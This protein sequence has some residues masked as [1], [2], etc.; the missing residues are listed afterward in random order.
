MS[1]NVLTQEP[2]K[3][4]SLGLVALIGVSGSGKST[5]ARQ[6]F[7]PT[8]VLSSDTCRGWVADDEADQTATDD[9]F[10]VLYAVAERRLRR[11]KL[12]VVDATS[13]Q[14]FAR[15][16]IVELARTQHVFASA[17]VLDVPLD[18][19]LAR[20]AA[21]GDRQV[22]E[23]AIRRQYKELRRSLDH[24]KK[25]G[26]RNV[27]VLT[28]EQ[29]VA[30]A[31]F[32]RTRMW[33]DRTD[34]HGPFDII[35][36]VHGCIDELEA[37]LGQLGYQAADR[38]GQAVWA[39]PEGR[40]ALF[41]GDLCDR[42]PGTP[43]VYRLVMA[44]VRHKTGLCIP[45]NHEIKLLKWLQGRNVRMTHGLDR[46][47]QQL[48]AEP[49]AFR[50]EVAAF[51]DRLIS[52]FVLDDGKL[53]VAHAG[54]KEAMQG[55]SSGGV[56][57]FCLYGET[58]GET[59]EYGLPV[60]V[61][62]AEQYR[63]RALVVYGH[64]PVLSVQWRHNTVC[65][66]T[67]CV[68]GGALTALRYPE[69]ETVSVPARQV[70]FASP[71]PLQPKAPVVEA[72][73]DVADLLG[74][75]TIETRLGF[76]VSISERDAAGGLEVMARFAA[77][78]RWLVYL[79]PTMSPCETAP[80]GEPWLEHPTQALAYYRE[81]GV[82]QVVCEQKHMGSRAV[83]V[84]CKDGPAAQAA[85]SIDN[86]GHGVVLSRT[87][88]AF[89][90]DEA[91]QAAVLDRLRE[92]CTAA[93]LWQELG[94]GW[95]LFDC[96][97]LPWS[98]KARQLIRRQFA[99]TGAAGEAGLAAA[100]AALARKGPAASHLLDDYAAR[101]RAV[102][103]YRTAYRSYCRPVAG[104]DDLRLAPFHLLASAG[105]VHTDKDHLWHM[106]V[107]ER[108]AQAEPRL[109]VATQHR[110][111]QLDDDGSCS[112]A[113]AWWQQLVDAGGEGMVCKP[114]Q[115]LTPGK[116]GLVQPAV[117]CRGPE[118]LRI[119]Y[120]PEYLLPA[121]L[122]RLRARGLGGKRSL[123]MREFALGI[124]GLQ[125]FVAGESQRRVHEC[126]FGV[127]ALESEPGDPRL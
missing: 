85:F 12:T 66:D 25:E 118:Y 41:L 78:P 87:G 59:D 10:A 82:A 55:R 75:R 90:D 14:P 76:P 42:G 34:D 7:L 84:L 88:R 127:L 108:L 21:R 71:K 47:V 72:G 46:S 109:C 31:T 27:H 58:T 23:E 19:C 111:V 48:L 18:V 103:Q 80:E 115:W 8:E 52:H 22:P 121:N 63:G 97:L 110:V 92:A 32:E 79:P 6:H 20:N 114:L 16:G 101:Q 96:E 33:H 119:I 100:V 89:F 56:R 68:F 104:L 26:F 35:G 113:V 51:I 1:N 61:D 65:I 77:D 13:V 2:L 62:W 94:T 99:A 60:R 105:A 83:V 15:K 81:Q 107:A 123:A 126:V 30:S 124:E 3:I 93:G 102:S 4:P 36:D 9:A 64:T 73:L 120:G 53:V 117:K 122:S 37:L 38:D 11:G 50:A 106:A 43:A 86:T 112:E 40:R 29:A 44:M 49:E 74:R 28:G 54:L 70:Y 39:H 91:L 17:V 95:L 45:G 125:R 69:R 98:A 57:E 5:F 67:G 24:L 116:K